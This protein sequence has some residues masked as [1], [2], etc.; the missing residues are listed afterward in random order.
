MTSPFHE[1]LGPQKYGDFVFE[2]RS[3]LN[4]PCYGFSGPNA[5][6]S[7][8]CSHNPTSLSETEKPLGKP[9]LPNSSK[10]SFKFYMNA[11]KSLSNCE[12]AAIDHTTYKSSLA[13][14][15]TVQMNAHGYSRR[16]T[17]EEYE[18]KFNGDVYYDGRSSESR[19]LYDD[20]SMVKTKDFNQLCEPSYYTKNFPCVQYIQTA[21]ESDGERTLKNSSHEIVVSAKK[22][23]FNPLSEPFHPMRNIYSNMSSPATSSECS[24]IASTTATPET[25]TKT[26]S[27]DQIKS[28]QFVCILCPEKYDTLDELKQHLKNKVQ[29]PHTCVICG[30]SFTHNYLLHR[31]MKQHRS[32]KVFRCRCCNK[33]FRSLNQLGKHFDFCRYKLYMFI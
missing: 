15:L 5:C 25:T 26:T 21:A 7:T 18:Q 23:T 14:H 28:E 9:K 11:K 31:H 33:K 4:T 2:W 29:Q 12:R 30:V 6:Y 27:I 20:L 10:M 17:Y 1:A 16:N 24:S 8:T 3:L 22:Y 19:L 32:L 13:T